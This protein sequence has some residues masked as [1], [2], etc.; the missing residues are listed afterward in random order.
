MSAD[1]I[2]QADN[3]PKRTS[4]RA[5]Q[6]LQG[7]NVTVIKRQAQS[8]DLNLIKMLRIDVQKESEKKKAKENEEFEES[9]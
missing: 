5:K 4:R 8:P 2:F 1:W 9:E 6:F 7:H 3:D